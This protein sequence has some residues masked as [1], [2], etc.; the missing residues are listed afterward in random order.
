MDDPGANVVRRES[1]FNLSRETF[2]IL[3]QL[4]ENGHG[5]GI[6]R[7][8]GSANRLLECEDRIVGTTDTQDNVHRR[9]CYEQ[10][11]NRSVRTLKDRYC[12][13]FWCL[14]RRPESPEVLGTEDAVISERLLDW[15][16]SFGFAMVFGV[17]HYLAGVKFAV[18]SGIGGAYFGY[19]NLL[20]RW[21]GHGKKALGVAAVHK[22]GSPMTSGQ[23]TTRNVLRLVD[24]TG[25]YLVGL[26]F[27]L[28]NDDRQ[29]FGDKRANTVV[30]L[31]KEGTNWRSIRTRYPQNQ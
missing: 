26:M 22:N 25:N 4:V 17:V 23:A 31:K 3:G 2:R 1:V 11:K 15:F 29:R 30:L 19:I 20:E 10:A 27:M 6:P 8:R 24:G 9:A 21:T 14:Y 28:V 13:A 7:R 18:L 16:L 5:E 12:H